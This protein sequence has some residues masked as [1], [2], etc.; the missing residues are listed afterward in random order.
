MSITCQYQWGLQGDLDFFAM[1]YVNYQIEKKKLVLF[2]VTDYIFICP[3]GPV[4][5]YLALT[6]VRDLDSHISAVLYII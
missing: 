1:L 6:L 4:K 5:Q 2:D 3:G